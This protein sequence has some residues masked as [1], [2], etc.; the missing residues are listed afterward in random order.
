MGYSVMGTIWGECSCPWGQLYHWLLVL[1][2]AEVSHQPWHWSP[3]SPPAPQHFSFSSRNEA[4]DGGRVART[5]PE[6]IPH[7]IQL[8]TAT[9]IGRDE[10]GLGQT[11]LLYSSPWGTPAPPAALAAPLPD[12]VSSPHGFASFTPVPWSSQQDSNKHKKRVCV[13]A[14]HLSIAPALPPPWAEP[15]GATASPC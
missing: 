4:L 7:L 13:Q 3:T 14:S 2:W 1:G 12:L 11:L 6:L 8:P 10:L 5:C 9:G 15:A